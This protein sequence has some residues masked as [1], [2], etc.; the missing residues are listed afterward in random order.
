MPRWNILG[1]YMTITFAEIGKFI[2]DNLIWFLIPIIVFILTM[3]VILLI[4][5]IE[6]RKRRK[7]ERKR[8]D[9]LSDSR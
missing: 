4:K 3:F 1:G 6:A 8:Q 2:T 7:Y 9:K 5:V